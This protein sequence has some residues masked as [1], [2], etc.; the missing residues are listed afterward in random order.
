[1]AKTA[2]LKSATASVRKEKPAKRKLSRRQREEAAEREEFEWNRV[3]H[4]LQDGGEQ[5]AAHAIMTME[6][7]IVALG[8]PAAIGEWLAPGEWQRCSSSGMW[9]E[10]TTSTS[11]L[12]SPGLGISTSTQAC[13]ACRAGAPGC[14]NGCGCPSY[15]QRS[16]P[17]RPRRP[18]ASFIFGPGGQPWGRIR[19]APGESL[20]RCG[21]LR[22][23]WRR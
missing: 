7:L 2:T 1:M 16:R 3:W 15:R 19:L 13:S 11:T 8:G 21:A 20:Y 18:A 5:Q 17:R 23:S 12:R 22:C 9:P 10:A 4:K 6:Q 14:P